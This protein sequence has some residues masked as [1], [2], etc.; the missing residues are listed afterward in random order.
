MWKRD[1]PG[2]TCVFHSR[3]TR[4]SPVRGI[5]SRIGWLILHTSVVAPISVCLPASGGDMDFLHLFFSPFFSPDILMDALNKF[6]VRTE[7]TGG[8]G[9]D[10]RGRLTGES[11]SSI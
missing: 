3:Q 4:H 8:G 11:A 10:L 6:G 7:K 5:S 1:N 2:K 9:V